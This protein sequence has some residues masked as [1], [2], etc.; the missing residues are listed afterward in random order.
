MSGPSMAMSPATWVWRP[1][2][3]VASSGCGPCSSRVALQRSGSDSARSPAR[4][5]GTLSLRAPPELPR[6]HARLGRLGA[7]VFRS[8]V[9]LVAAVLGLP[10]LL[11][12]NRSRRR[13]CLPRSSAPRTPT[14]VGEPGACSRGYAGVPFPPNGRRRTSSVHQVRPF[15]GRHCTSRPP[16]PKHR[17]HLR[18]LRG[19][20]IS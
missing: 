4:D 1:S 10:L 8:S 3:S 20:E 6:Y 12:A 18:Q 17:G 13:R 5:G 7:L 9:G 15:I 16:P 11:R 2:S 19:C 14:T